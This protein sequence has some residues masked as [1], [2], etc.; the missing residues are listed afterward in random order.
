MFCYKC[1]AK[2]D[3]SAIFCQYCGAKVQ[4]DIKDNIEN[5]PKE[6]SGKKNISKFT[7]ILITLL[8]GA[9]ALSIGVL[10]SSNPNTQDAESLPPST[11]QPLQSN[12]PEHTASPTIVSPEPKVQETESPVAN[13]AVQEKKVATGVNYNNKTSHDETVIQE[14]NDVWFDS[15]DIYIE[16]RG[17]EEES[18]SKWIVSLY[19]ENNRDSEI[20]LFLKGNRL[21]NCVVSL[22]NNG[23]TIPAGSKYLSVPKYNFIVD[24]EEIAEYGLTSITQFDSTLNICTDFFGDTIADVNVHSELAKSV[25]SV[26]LSETPADNSEIILDENDILVKYTGIKEYSADSWIVNV[27]VENNRDSSIYFQL[28]D[29]QI[30]SFSLDLS[31]NGITIPAHSKYIA[32]PNFNLI[33]DVDDL[34]SYGITSIDDLDFTVD[35]STSFIGEKICE[36]PFSTTLN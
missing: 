17:L 14:I 7:L 27:S 15:D 25:P 1:G 6:K 10:I 8:V 28:R 23:I 2:I 5:F 16:F 3:D 18:S 21:N 30:N 29:I 32:F 26:Y 4:S 9:L 20:Y 35:I 22:A 36:V 13:Y 33:I 11:E 31:N 34:D 19:V 12:S 24:I